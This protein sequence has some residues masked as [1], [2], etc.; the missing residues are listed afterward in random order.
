MANDQTA[1]SLLTADL[2]RYDSHP[3]EVMQDYFAH[4]FRTLRF[5]G[6][7]DAYNS[8][9]SNLNESAPPWFCSAVFSDGS[10]NIGY[11]RRIVESI[12][13]MWLRFYSYC[14]TN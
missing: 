8:N 5:S 10:S 14:T 2:L 4:N 11:R 3:S 12:L 13:W 7:V 6:V 1:N 9:T